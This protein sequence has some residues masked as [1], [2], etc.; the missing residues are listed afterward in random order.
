MHLQLLLDSLQFFDIRQYLYSQ[1]QNFFKT[2]LAS[3]LIIFLNTTQ[4]IHDS[5]PE[6]RRIIA[7][8]CVYISNG[9]VLDQAWEASQAALPYLANHR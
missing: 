3:R 1:L 5:G 9:P 8:R 6:F 4:T 2:G 7:R